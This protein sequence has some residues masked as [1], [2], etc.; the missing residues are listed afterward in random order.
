MKQFKLLIL[1]SL[2]LCIINIGF[3]QTQTD[4]IKT[5]VL[6]LPSKQT[7]SQTE[8]NFMPKSFRKN[9]KRQQKRYKKKMKKEQKI[10]N[11]ST[12]LWEKYKWIKKI[13]VK[14]YKRN[15]RKKRK[16]N[17]RILKKKNHSGKSFRIFLIIR[18]I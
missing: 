15:Q 9:Y 11:K 8:L 6:K 17:Q 12:N 1:V 10:R 5:K 4:S 2:L 18:Y 3:S 14:I 16:K 13:Q 7:Y